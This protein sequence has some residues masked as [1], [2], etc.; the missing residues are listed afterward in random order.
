MRIAQ[1]T[2]TPLRLDLL[3]P[4]KT[5]RSTYPAR[6]GYLVRLVDEDGRVGHGEAMP[7]PE[8]G[9]ES[10]EV[11]GAMLGAWLSSLKGQFLGDSVRAIEDTLSPFP[12]AVARGDGVR[13][14]AQHPAPE[15]PVP[16]A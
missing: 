11:C 3:Q 10:L 12:R 5:S 15:G 16:A 6:E 7:L 8:F 1:A 9:T 2:L 4:L 14:R 13:I